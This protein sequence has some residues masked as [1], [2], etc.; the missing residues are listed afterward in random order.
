M[1]GGRQVGEDIAFFVRIHC[2]FR[3]W[4]DD[5]LTAQAAILV[6]LVF[7]GGCDFFYEIHPLVGGV[8]GHFH[9][10]GWIS[11][12]G[13]DA[14][15]HGSASA[16][17]A[18]EGTRVD[19]L[20]ALDAV[21]FQISGKVGIRAPIADDRAEF[22]DHEAAHLRL[23]A[24]HIDVIHAVISDFRIGHRHNLAAIGRIGEDF[25]IAAHRGVEANLASGRAL[26]SER[27]AMKNPSIL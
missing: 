17:V 22:F 26:R 14:C 8:T 13:G 4:A 10:L 21:F 16:E 25:L 27:L 23:V 15:P 7:F 5:P 2:G 24:L 20:N 9:G 1:G 19:A 3:A 11:G 12:L 18:G 6:P